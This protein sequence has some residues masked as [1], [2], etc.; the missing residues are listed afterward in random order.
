[1]RLV[2]LIHDK[3]GRR[4]ALVQ[5]PQLLLIHDFSSIYALAQAAIK[6]DGGLSTLVNEKVSNESLQYDAIYEGRSAWQL[7]PAF[8]HPHDLNACIL[9]GTG[10]THK[11]SADNRQAMH[12]AETEDTLTDSM[13]MYLW[14]LEKGKPSEGSVGVQPEWFY[15]GNG[16]LLKAHGEAL[17]VPAYADDGGEEPEIAGLYIIAPDGTPWR[18]GFATANEFSDHVMERKNYLYLAPSKLRHCALGPEL[19][20]RPDLEAVTGEV[21]VHR[22]GQLLWHKRIQTGEAN[23]SHSLANLEY[24]HFKYGHHLLPGQVHIHFL[25]ADA[26]SFGEQVALKDGD[27]MKVHWSGMGRPVVNPI[28]I[29]AESEQLLAIQ[30]MH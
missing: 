6:R 18:L 20:I 17:E 3:L 10:L 19:T 14:G 7:L 8:D 30:K 16:A 4:I 25:G 11:A 28:S 21:S 23:M 15:K 26:F 12:D 24:H 5:E 29:S 9:S 13:K 27:L 22:E 2:Q 1:M